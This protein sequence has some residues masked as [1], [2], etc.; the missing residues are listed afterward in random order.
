LGAQRNNENGKSINDH[1]NENDNNDIHN[2]KEKEK[3]RNSQKQNEIIMRKIL[4]F[5][6]LINSVGLITVSASILE[7]H[8]LSSKIRQCSQLNFIISFI[9]DIINTL[10]LIVERRKYE[11][12]EIFVNFI[13]QLRSCLLILLFQKYFVEN[14]VNQNNRKICQEDNNKV[15]N[16]Q[17]NEDNKNED[18]FDEKIL[19]DIFRDQCKVILQE[20]EKFHGNKE[21]SVW[22]TYFIIEVLFHE[23]FKSE[24]ASTSSDLINSNFQISKNVSHKLLSFLGNEYLASQNHENEFSFLTEF[25]GAMVLYSTVMFQICLKLPFN[26]IENNF[27]RNNNS[28][29]NNNDNSDNN[30]RNNNI[31]KTELPSNHESRISTKHFTLIDIESAARVVLCLCG[32]HHDENDHLPKKSE[33]TQAMYNYTKFYA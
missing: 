26:S 32:D 11:N 27:D 5:L 33:S 9:S 30:T 18:V 15:K 19:L 13:P 17:D 25:A 6:S 10:I 1:K 31:I 24:N 22:T 28:N 20:N 4:Q 3:E 21:I 29:N 23:N 2:E 7:K 8:Y 12:C 14:L 16:K